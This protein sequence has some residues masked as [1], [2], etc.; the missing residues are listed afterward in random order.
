MIKAK[1]LLELAGIVSVILGLIFV[2]YELQEN[3][4]SMQAQTRAIVSQISV[5]NLISMR[6]D[7]RLI[8]LLSDPDMVRT[9]ADEFRIDMWLLQYTRS[10]ENAYYQYQ[11]GLFELEEFESQRL[12]NQIPFC[13][14]RNRYW[15]ERS[16]T[17]FSNSFRD[18]FNQTLQ[19][20]CSDNGT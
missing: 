3:R 7:D 13:I 5:E 1:S 12:S 9:P 18:Y 6:E 11:L 8:E 14:A 20:E 15:W 10:A 4:L 16:K 2:R 19:A 17:R